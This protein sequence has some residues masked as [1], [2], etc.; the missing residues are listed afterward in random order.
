MRR[1]D[2]PPI[3]EQVPGFYPGG[4]TALKHLSEQIDAYIPRP[5]RWR[6]DVAARPVKRAEFWRR[7]FKFYICSLVLGGTA[8]LILFSAFGS[9]AVQDGPLTE[10]NSPLGYM[11][12]LTLILCSA[13]FL[14][15]IGGRFLD[16]GATTKWP[17][18]AHR[19]L[20]F[21]FSLLLLS[22]LLQSTGLGFSEGLIAVIFLF[23]FP[24]HLILT[25]GIFSGFVPSQKATSP[26]H[27]DPHEVSP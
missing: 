2:L 13:H 26:H 17:H 24:S 12:F 15:V 20:V 19:L 4:R 25:L 8:Y 14:P 10:S 6:R 16:I 5:F 27:A 23:L 21:P 11:L 22:V 9:E 18:R 7:F 1:G 3:S